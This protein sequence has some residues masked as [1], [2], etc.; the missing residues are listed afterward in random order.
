MHN[1]NLAH[2]QCICEICCCMN[3]NPRPALQN[4]ISVCSFV[5]AW[6]RHLELLGVS[7]ESVAGVHDNISKFNENSNSCVCNC[8]ASAF[9]ISL[10]PWDGSNAWGAPLCSMRDSRREKWDA[11]VEWHTLTPEEQ[12]AKYYDPNLLSGFET[13]QNFIDIDTTSDSNEE[14]SHVYFDA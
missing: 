4:Y 9:V 12:C 10:S 8:N 7:V 1:F 2:T 6:E 3:R 11:L 13:Q 5:G 14:D